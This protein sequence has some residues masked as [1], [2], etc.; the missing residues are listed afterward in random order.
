MLGRLFG[1]CIYSGVVAAYTLSTDCP[2][3][4]NKTAAACLVDNQG[5]VS[6]SF[7]NVTPV[8][9]LPNRNITFVDD[10]PNESL[11]M[12][13]DLGVVFDKVCVDRDLSYNSITSLPWRAGTQADVVSLDL[14]HNA[15]SDGSGV[16]IPHSV[17]YLNLSYN[18]IKRLDQD[19]FHL[20]DKLTKL[21]LQHNGMTEI[22][23]VTFPSSL[24][25]L[26]L[27]DNPLQFI[28]LSADAFVK[29]KALGSKLRLKMTNMAVYSLYG[30]CTDGRINRLDEGL[31]C[32]FGNAASGSTVFEVSALSTNDPLVRLVIDTVVDANNLLRN[33]MIIVAV[34][35]GVLGVVFLVLWVRRIRTDNTHRG[36]FSSSA[37]LSFSEEPPQFRALLTPRQN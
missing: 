14:S 19:S 3:A 5:L 33:L 32:V 24:T 9:S 21:H 23:N 8:L 22:V 13:V 15:L 30:R 37:C 6:F 20:S 4:G 2:L 29:L 35:S 11:I 28:W 10:F 34:L 7:A 1:C 31:V 26:D 25:E 36:T 27:S 18:A 12:Y 17:N 16:Y